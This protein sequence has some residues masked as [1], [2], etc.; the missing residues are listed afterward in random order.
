MHSLLLP[1][2]DPDWATLLAGVPTGVSSTISAVVPI[3]VPVMIALAGLS[4]AIAI[5]RKFGIRT[6]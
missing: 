2:T 5:F 4:I 3:A 6:R 1:L